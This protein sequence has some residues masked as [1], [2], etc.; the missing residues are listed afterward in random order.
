MILLRQYSPTEEDREKDPSLPPHTDRRHL[1]QKYCQIC[2]KDLI[3]YSPNPSRGH[4]RGTFSRENGFLSR[5]PHVQAAMQCITC[6]EM[7]RASSSSSTLESCYI[8]CGECYNLQRGDHDPT[9][10]FRLF[11]PERS[12][13][14]MEQHTTHGTHSG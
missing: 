12:D 9:H 13:T 3:I 7:C 11:R 5:S 10:V 4:N 14:E 8:I 6:Q 1:P 2:W